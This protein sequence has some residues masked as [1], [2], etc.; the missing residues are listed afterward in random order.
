M[1]LLR[2]WFGLSDRVDRRTYLVHGTLLM[3]VKYA[4]DAAAVGALAGVLWTPLDYLNPLFSTRARALGPAPGWLLAAMAVWALPFLWIG[5]SMSLRRLI[6]AGDSPWLCLFYFVPYLNWVFFA[7]LA[8]QPSAPRPQRK[9][10]REEVDDILRATLLGIGA[11]LAIGAVSFALHVALLKQ[12]S[13]T[14]FLGTPFTMGAA[15][16]YLYNRRRAR[17]ARATAGVGAL[18][19]SLSCAALL[20]FAFEGAIC[21]I[22]AAPLVLTVAVLGALIGRAIAQEARASTAAAALLLFLLPAAGWAEARL[23]AKPEREVLS[24]VEIDAPPAR[25]WTHVVAFSELPAPPEW[26]FALGIAFPQRARIDGRGPGAVRRCEFSTGAFVEP[27]TAWDEPA[28]LAF[29]VASQP[30]PMHEWSPYRHVHPPHLDATLRS[31]R[32]EFR[33][34]ALPGGRTRLEGR[35]WYTLQLFP[36]AYWAVWSDLLVHRIHERV[37]QHIRRL[38]ERPPGS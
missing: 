24:T 19:V 7:V 6:D 20:L 29:D 4:V 9:E 33:L 13:S 30:P 3:A 11:S 35:T 21:L 8:A 1:R 36:D 22:M 28:R 18:A 12:Y 38:S 17:S 10:D 14:V 34:I 25:V 2:L 23:A 27:I 31:R 15:A 37:L 16:G 5:V 26:F 32:G